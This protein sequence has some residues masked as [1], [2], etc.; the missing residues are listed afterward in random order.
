LNCSQNQEITVKKPN[1]STHRAPITAA[2]F[3]AVALISAALAA[4]ADSNDAPQAVVKYG[5][6]NLSSPR[7]AGLLYNRIAEAAGE[8]CR[9]SEIDSSNLTVQFRVRACI[10]KAI[11]DAVIKIGRP[12]LFAIYKVKMAHPVAAT[13]A[14]AQAR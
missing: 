4:A 13:V 7:S 6:L 2:I 11:A 1:T 9:A 10:H 3:G 5:D 12:E 8:V 14:V